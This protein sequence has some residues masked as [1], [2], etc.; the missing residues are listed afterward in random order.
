LGRIEVGFT[1]VVRIGPEAQWAQ[2]DTPGE[3]VILVVRETMQRMHGCLWLRP[4]HDGMARLGHAE[5][6]VR[7][8]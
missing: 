5:S 6:E 1:F 7:D 2:T 4:P 8:V 3:D